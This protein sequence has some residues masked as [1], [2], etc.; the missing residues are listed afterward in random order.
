MPYNSQI[1]MSG[2]F[3]LDL[4]QGSGGRG[5]SFS[6]VHP[7][8]FQPPTSPSVSSSVYLGRST[9][10]L[11]SETLTPISTAKRKRIGPKESTPLRDWGMA[12][13]TDDII[14]DR[15]DFDLNTCGQDRRYVL[16][17]QIDT[18]DGGIQRELG[19]LEDSVY[20]DVDYRRALGP[21]QP[22]NGFVDSPELRPME[23]DSNNDGSG[24]WSAFAIT[25]IGGV[26]GRVWQFCKTGS[27]RGF[28]A[29]GG[30]GYEM[31][32][33]VGQPQAAGHMG[34]DGYRASV[35][36]H[37]HEPSLLD[38]NQLQSDYYEH[39]TPE[40]TPPPP[41][42]RRQISHGTPTDELR[43]NWVM[44]DEPTNVNRQSSLASRASSRQ[45]VQRT[46]APSLVRRI[47]KPVSRLNAPNFNRH[48][49]SRPSS[50]SAGPI[51][52]RESASFASTRS[53][54]ASPVITSRTP[55]RIPV[56]SRAQSPSTF[57]GSQFAPQP[58]RIPS[59]SPYAKRSHRRSQSAVS[60]SAV[61]PMK[62]KKRES[63]HEMHDN[64]PRLDAK[65]RSLAAKRM[66]NEM[67]TDMR[68][69]DFNSRLRDMIRQGKEALGTTYEVESDND[70]GHGGDPWESE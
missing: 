50:A 11:Q 69:N 26:V 43:K 14:G 60:A 34:A 48:P 56:A 47:S 51:S 18:P 25:T 31:S 54:I 65:A 10:S 66:Q 55:S 9:G 13:D 17:G 68:I 37:G 19:C 39:G 29:G 40:S 36:I 24:G 28:Y 49:P 35:G 52:S 41:A 58:S 59:P 44:I 8:I 3:H 6:A 21:K 53:P 63:L 64:S 42:K 57:G 20:S 30:I 45:P 46:T 12:T 70:Y 15:Y 4:P 33:A 22:Y 62:M 27:F 16:A 5:T 32:K 67:E 7:G 2:T 38:G 1:L 23:I 61:S